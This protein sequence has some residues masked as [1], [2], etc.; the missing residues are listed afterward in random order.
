MQWPLFRK[1]DQYVADSGHLESFAKQ[2]LLHSHPHTPRLTPADIK[3]S[4]RNRTHGLY[5]AHCLARA[6]LVVVLLERRV[7]VVSGGVVVAMLDSWVRSSWFSRRSSRQCYSNRFE[8]T[9]CST[10]KNNQRD[11]PE[12]IGRLREEKQLLLCTSSTN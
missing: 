8:Q 10:H 2:A 11:V 6:D 7:V 12:R 1:S 4:T 3:T 9:N 5:L